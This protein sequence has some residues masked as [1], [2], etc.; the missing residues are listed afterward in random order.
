MPTPFQT[1]SEVLSNLRDEYLKAVGRLQT[2]DK[3]WTKHSSMNLCISITTDLKEA[4]LQFGVI[5]HPALFLNLDGRWQ[6]I[7]DI[8][9][10]L[11]IFGPEIAT[12]NKS[13]IYGKSLQDNLILA[14]LGLTL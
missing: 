1:P 11:P 10:M 8:P 3:S 12:L 13:F 2:I 5:I 4:F 6:N 7:L 14:G 9:G